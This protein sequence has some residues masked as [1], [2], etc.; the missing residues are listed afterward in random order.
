MLNEPNDKQMG[1]PH[2]TSHYMDITCTTKRP[3]MEKTE[4]EIDFEQL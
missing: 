1:H 4:K 2:S 3:N